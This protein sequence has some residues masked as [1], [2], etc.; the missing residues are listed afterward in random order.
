MQQRNCL[1]LQRMWCMSSRGAVFVLACAGL[2]ALAAAPRLL[3]FGEQHDQPD[4]QRQVA[5]AVQ[6]LAGR[7]ALAAVVLEMAEAPHST[8]A[9]PRDAAEAQVRDA[10]QWRGWPW[11]P[12]A[13]VVMNAVRAGVP[14]LGGNLPR[15]AMRA[16]MADTA[17]DVQ[18][19]AAARALLTD[20][21]RTGHCDLLPAAQEPGMVRIQ[22]ARDQSMARVAAQASGTAPPGSTVLLLA[23]AMH[24]SRDR[25][26]PLHLQRELS[27]RVVPLH[28]VLFSP[29]TDG[30]SAD[31][32]RIAEVTPQPDPCEALRQQL[33]APRPASSAPR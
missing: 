20:A 28:V 2:P 14:V 24:A 26:V 9:L 25:G 31:E 21:V 22:I 17:L 18:V 16:A 3:I 5:E 29:A 11:E 6:A 7:G 33:A 10:L 4:Q 12:Y 19:D 23:G 1:T 15:A 32:R 27:P 13:A 30:L 8:A